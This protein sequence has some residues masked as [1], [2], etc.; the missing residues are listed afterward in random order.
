MR[1]LRGALVAIVTLSFAFGLGGCG[2]RLTTSR[3]VETTK[4]PAPKNN[5][6]SQPSSKDTELVRTILSAVNQS[7]SQMQGYTGTLLTVDQTGEKRA[8]GEA[9]FSF[10]KPSK[11]RIDIVSNSGDP[12][13]AGTK[14][15]WD[16]S[17]NVQVRAAGML[18][19]MKVNLS[20]SDGRL[21]SYNGYTI[22]QLHHTA[23]L[24]A[25]NDPNAVIKPLGDQQ[26]EAKQVTVLDVAGVSI[27]PGVD[28][29]HVGIDRASRMPILVE[30]YKGNTLTYSLRMT[31]LS[32]TAPQAKDFSI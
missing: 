30:F 16:G 21:K 22:A 8:I 27:A 12:G 7:Y 24:K 1:L 26:V 11:T 9:K 28:H 23:V 17:S 4:M 18:G 29:C 20:M 10:L 15:Y 31:N 13:K 19:V 6:E 14:V 3:T 5:F 2:T 32:T 25:L